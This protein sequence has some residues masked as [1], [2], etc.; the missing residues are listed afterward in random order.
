MNK[1][2]EFVSGQPRKGKSYYVQEKLNKSGLSVLYITT[3]KENFKGYIQADIESPLKLISDALELKH[4]ILYKVDYNAKFYKKEIELLIKMLFGLKS[5]GFRCIVVFDECHNY[6]QEGE[7]DN[8]IFRI[9]QEGLTELQTIFISQFPSGVPKRILR[10]CELHTFFS[11]TNYEEKYFK[12]Y[13]LPT[14]DI[15]AGLINQYDKVQI[16]NGEVVK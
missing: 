5:R 3:K 12:S 10:S 8:P 15:K 7:S 16:L 6:A 11:M 13:G 9:A 4:K 2:N 1:V 14:D